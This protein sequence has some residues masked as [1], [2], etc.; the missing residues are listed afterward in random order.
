MDKEELKQLVLDEWRNGYIVFR[1]IE[2]L[3]KQKI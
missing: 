3:H 2:G 1:T